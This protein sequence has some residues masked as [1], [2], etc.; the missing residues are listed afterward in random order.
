M[1]RKPKENYASAKK[2]LLLP[3][4]QLLF[5]VPM[6][7]S[8]QKIVRTILLPYR[9]PKENYASAKKIV[10]TILLPYRK[11]AICVENFLIQT[12]THTKKIFLTH[13]KQDLILFC[14]QKIYQT[15][16]RHSLLLFQIFSDSRSQ[17]KNGLY[18]VFC[19]LQILQLTYACRQ[20]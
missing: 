16:V 5:I 7:R 20:L 19:I 17:T 1:Y 4:D 12:H 10:R 9:K 13:W 18:S 11:V 15:L 8:L 2:I 3:K 6:L 14:H